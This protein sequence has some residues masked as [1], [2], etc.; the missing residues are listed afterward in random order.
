MAKF[1]Y[2]CFT[3]VFPSVSGLG[4]GIPTTSELKKFEPDGQFEISGSYGDA[5]IKETMQPLEF[6]VT[7]N[8]MF[9]TT[10]RLIRGQ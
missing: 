2:A 10:W 6:A 9:T 4:Q 3:V 8:D 5:E 1:L 7:L